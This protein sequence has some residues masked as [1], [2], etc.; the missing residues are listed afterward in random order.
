MTKKLE[1][2]IYYK[3]DLGVLYCGDNNEIL[4]LIT[5]PIDL[6]LTDPPYGIDNKI[7]NHNKT[8]QSAGN[9]FAIKYD[10]AGRWD[11]NRPDKIIFDILFKISKNQVICGAN[12]F[13]E[14]L[15]VSRGWVYWDKMGKGMSSVNNELIF[16]S[17]DRSILEFRRCHGL[18]KGFM[19][20]EDLA[21]EHPTSKPT[22][23]M[24]FLIEKCSKE[25]D[26]L[27]DPFIG[28]GTTAVCCEK[29]NRKWIGI[30]IS[31]KYC[32]IAAKRIKIEADQLKMFE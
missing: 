15:P 25:L 6:V 7:T 29:M 12:Y 30:E 23:L 27:I 31:E 19:V 3:T 24:C 11:K 13:V 8:K 22:A 10:N 28:G 20:K 18:D 14:F 16:T 1:D 4:P 5:E 32:E 21:D 9:K 26:V 17:Y 2:Y